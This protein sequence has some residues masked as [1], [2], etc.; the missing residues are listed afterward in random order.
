MAVE[1]VRRS[2]GELN[3]YPDASGY[4]LRAKLAERHGLSPDHVILGCGSDEI[5][6]LLG[7]M[8]LVPD[9]SLVMAHPSFMRYG[10]A[11]GLAGANLVKVP[12]S[13]AFG[14]DVDALVQAVG[15][16]TRLVFLAN[17][18]NPTGTTLSAGDLDRILDRMPDSALVVVDEAYVEFAKSF[19]GPSHPDAVEL[20]KSGR[21]VVALRT[22]SKAYG[23]AG[24]RVGYGF[25]EPEVVRS[26]N[27]A[28]PPFDVNA[29]A[30]AAAIAALDDGAHLERTLQS[31]KEG[32]EFLTSEAAALGLATVPSAANFVC[33]EVGDAATV[34]D[35]LLHQG[36]IVRPGA[37]LGMPRHIRVSVG[38]RHE[39]ERFVEALKLSLQVEV[40]A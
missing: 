2:A 38:A 26:F 37:Q 17:P 22:F 8:F 3:L 5:I 11:A 23:L 35:R 28:R 18:N 12:M 15:P 6:G 10:A 34:A 13:P 32:M 19:L 14:F 20:L 27:A 4:A 7:A 33:L 31:N 36:V 39:N 30:Q 29:L 21:R 1:A 40:N 24:I 25:A 16:E 9:T